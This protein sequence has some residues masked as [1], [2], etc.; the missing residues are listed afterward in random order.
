MTLRDQNRAM[1]RYLKSLA[2]V[3]LAALALTLGACDITDL[4]ENPNE[5]TT[6][7]PPNLLTNAEVDIAT[8]YWGAFTLGRFANLYAQYWTQNQYTDEDRYG[9]PSRRS[10]SLNAMWEDYYLALNDL[11]QI[12]RI[13]EQT[14][15]EVEGFGPNA[16]QI[17]ISKIMQA[18]TFQVMTDIWGPI[19][20]TEA[21][22]GRE[23]G[24]FQPSY[25]AQEDIY[26]G[27]LD[28]LTAA[29]EMI[30]TEASALASGDIIYNGDMEQWKKFANSTK[31]RVAIRIADRLPDVAEA[32]INEAIE[33]GVFEEVDDAA[34]VPFSTSPPYQNPIYENYEV[35]G[36]DD[37]AMPNSIIAPMLATDDPRLPA[38]ATATP[39]GE[40]IGYTYGLPPGEAQARFQAGP[41]S[42]PSEAVREADAPAILMLY[43]EVLFIKAEAAQRGFIDGDAAEF[44]RE[45]ITASV[46]YWDEVS[47]TASVSEDEIDAFID[48]VPYD[49]SNW[50]QVLGVQKWLAL[51]MQGIQG[52]SEFRRLDFEG[53]L[54]PPP[55][56]PGSEEFGVPIAVRLPYPN[57]ETSLNGANVEEA[58]S[59]LLDG[60]D[61]QGTKLWWDVD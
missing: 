34:L 61:D 55:G 35:S 18:W 21:L 24:N 2:L 52:W 8:N 30:D 28:S 9:Y 20:F 60:P 58:V 13:N 36:R 53:I 15:G 17:A 40:Y 51:Y 31:M 14:P 11:Q 45:A 6:V 5:P 38:Y 42:R 59:N 57:D 23:S 19:P 29:S 27:L 1:K 48:R 50:Q 22:Q 32:A 54:Q 49:A 12:V 25:T 41:F 16:N 46:S 56:D 47:A 4:N 44:Y 26:L 43:D 37:W 7:T 10:G 33:A 39:G 3:G